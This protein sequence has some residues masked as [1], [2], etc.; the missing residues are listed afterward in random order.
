MDEKAASVSKLPLPVAFLEF[1][2]RNGVDPSI[3]IAASQSTPR[4]IRLKPGC[5]TRI[6]EIEEEVKCKVRKVSWL[7][8]FYFL[9]PD[10]QIASTKAYQEGKIYG[11]DAASGAAVV[12][13]NVLPGDHILDLCAAPG[14]KLCMILDLIGCSGSVTGVD[15]AR[16]RLAASRTMLR[17]YGLGDRCRL[18]VADG[19]IFSFI[20]PR[21]Q[22]NFILG[23]DEESE[24]YKEWTHRRPCKERKRVAKARENASSQ[25]FVKTQDPELIFYGS[26]SGV[27]G[28]RKSEV[29]RSVDDLEILQFGYDKLKL[30]TNGFRL[31]KVGGFLVYSTCSLTVAQNEDV[32]EQFLS[33]NL[34]AEMVEVEDATGWPCSPARIPKTLRFDPST[35]FTSGLF[36]AK[37][38]KLTIR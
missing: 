7:P 29:F 27:V 12:A 14:A 34:S 18:F 30:L 21:V 2:A 19:T 9:Q 28:L 36:I 22:S 6:T 24:I 26:N 3:Y 10:V 15:V 5:G 20:P 8:N 32:V 17:K 33:Q 4:Y 25:P 37:F 16:H 35:S 31:L 13:L 23:M 11:I 1:L 38:T